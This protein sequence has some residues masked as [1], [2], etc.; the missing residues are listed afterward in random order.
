VLCF[1]V[2]CF[3]VQKSFYI[4]KFY[5]TLTTVLVQGVSFYILY[6]YPTLTTV[7]VVVNA[8]VVGSTPGTQMRLRGSHAS[9]IAAETLTQ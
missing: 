6:F 1:L 2:F 5:L 8:A 7:V 4:L 3:L 9:L